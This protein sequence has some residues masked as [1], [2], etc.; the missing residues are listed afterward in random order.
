MNASLTASIALDGVVDKRD[1]EAASRQLAAGLAGR[2]ARDGLAY[3]GVSLEA[4]T[5]AGAA[6]ATARFARPQPPASLGTHLCMLL[7]RLGLSAPVERLTAAVAD[8]VPAPAQQLTLF[9]G[10]DSLRASR[11][12]QLLAEVNR[13]YPL[14][15]AASLEVDRREKVLAFYDPWRQRREGPCPGPSA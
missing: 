3:L 2:L 9:A 12:R 11:L 15:T 6:R 14:V 7:P 5:E 13:K 1:L 10:R 4:R 8:P